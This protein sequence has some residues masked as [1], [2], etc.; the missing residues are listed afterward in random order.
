MHHLKRVA[1]AAAAAFTLGSALGVDSDGFKTVVK[2]FFEAHCV[3]CHGPDKSK[4]K[5]TVHSLNGSDLVAGRDLEHWE[6]I[7]EVLADGEM[8]PEDEP[9][10]KEDARQAVAKWIEDGLR[11]YVEKAAQDPE[12]MKLSGGER[13]R[14]RRKTQGLKKRRRTSRGHF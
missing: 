7:L 9:Q 2:P 6:S 13:A 11:S 1:V 12:K 10:P 3:S 8:P 4:G 5:I 14:L